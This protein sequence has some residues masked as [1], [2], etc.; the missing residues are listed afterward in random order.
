[1]ASLVLGTVLLWPIHV[2]CCLIDLLVHSFYNDSVAKCRFTLHYTP[3][4]HLQPLP[5]LDS[6]SCLFTSHLTSKLQQII[7]IQ[8]LNVH[9]GLCLQFKHC[10]IHP[11]ISSFA[12]R[13][14]IQKFLN[15]TNLW[16]TQC[17]LHDACGT[18]LSHT[19]GTLWE[20]MP[21]TDPPVILL[22]AF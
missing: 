7:Y 14:G 12:R 22:Q 1:M 9:C 21:A 20:L 16:I 4:C 19:F 17:L 11:A 3:Q 6:A 15:T 2:F 10:N 5:R 13:H 18:E 8:C